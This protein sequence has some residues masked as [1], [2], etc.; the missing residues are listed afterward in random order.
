MVR[1][2]RRRRG[3]PPVEGLKEQRREQILEAATRIFARRGYPATDLQEVADAIRVGKGTLYRYFP[4]K[5]ALFLAAV[6]RGIG[7]LSRQVQSRTEALE[8][9]LERIA[10]A[11]GAYLE[12]F[13]RNPEILE[14]MA[15]ERAV[16]KGR[17]PTYFAFLDA[18]LGPWK[19]LLRTLMARGRVRKMPVDRIVDVVGD[20]VYGTIVT[21]YFTGRRRTA[22]AQARDLLDVVFHGILTPEERRARAAREKHP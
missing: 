17:Q 10:A 3:R 19:E 9:P 21:D 11:V 7:R 5:E 15:Q 6:E 20:A 1:S 4:T 16:F 18:R 22:E 13:S 14:L 8:D 12:Y 2:P